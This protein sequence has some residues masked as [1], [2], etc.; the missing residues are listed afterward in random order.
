[1]RATCKTAILCKICFAS[2]KM[3][4]N[5]VHVVLLRSKTASNFGPNVVLYTRK[6]VLKPCAEMHPEFMWRRNKI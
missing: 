6:T 4:Q 1:M 2:K 3:H 5:H